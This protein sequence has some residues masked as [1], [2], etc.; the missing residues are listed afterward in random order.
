MACDTFRKSV[1]YSFQN[2]KDKNFKNKI[3]IRNFDNLMKIDGMYTDNNIFIVGDASI[4]VFQELEN[5]GL[6]VNNA[7]KPWDLY[8]EIGLK[9]LVK[10]ALENFNNNISYHPDINFRQYK[11]YSQTILP[12]LWELG[13]KYDLIL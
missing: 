12:K 6:I 13:N 2:Q 3:E 10:L 1:F 8:D 4:R 9:S 5:N 7:I 11:G